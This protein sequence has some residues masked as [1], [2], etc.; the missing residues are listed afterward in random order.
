MSDVPPNAQKPG[1]APK[2]FASR[3]PRHIGRILAMQFLFSCDL[4]HDWKEDDASLALFREYA[5]TDEEQRLPQSEETLANATEYALGLI[6][7][8]CRE[9]ERLDQF[10]TGAAQNWSIGRMS[11]IDRNLMRIAVYELVCEMPNDSEMTAAIIINEAIEISKVFG[12]NNSSRFI[13]GVL[14]RIRRDLQNQ[15]FTAGSTDNH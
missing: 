13:N 14:D 6:R 11:C 15:P 4:T 10:I 1:A 7:G 3:L 5:V 9:R 12:D 2:K 8:V